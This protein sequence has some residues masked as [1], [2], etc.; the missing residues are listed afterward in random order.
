MRRVDVRRW[1]K[2][3]LPAKLL[4]AA[5]ACG[6]AVALPCLI[7]LTNRGGS[8]VAAAPPPRR[9]RRCPRPATRPWRR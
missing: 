9:R 2:V 8:T 1:G 3:S 7:A 5:A 4:F 6:L